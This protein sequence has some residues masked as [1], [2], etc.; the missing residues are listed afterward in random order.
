M[1]DMPDTQEKPEPQ[2]Q[3]KQPQAEGQVERRSLTDS[4]AVEYVMQLADAGLTSIT[5]GAGTA[6]GAHLVDKAIHRPKDPPPAEIH[7]EQGYRP[8][9]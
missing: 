5:M 7:V 3:S 1:G 9:E 8:K 4:G 6:Y 2:S